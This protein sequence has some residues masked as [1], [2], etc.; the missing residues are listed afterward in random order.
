MKNGEGYFSSPCPFRGN[1]SGDELIMSS[2]C[3]Y[4]SVRRKQ[5]GV[6]SKFGGGGLV[7]V[8]CGAEQRGVLSR[9]NLYYPLDTPCRSERMDWI[10]VSN[11]VVCSTPDCNLHH[12]MIRGN[13]HS[14]G[15]VFVFIVFFV[16]NIEN[17]YRFT[18]GSSS[19]KGL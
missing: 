14:T 4:W 12:Q 17:Q 5:P 2:S 15:R 16:H 3:T 1:V 19:V 8:V 10:G 9:N 11:M 13:Q 6:V 7:A 18:V